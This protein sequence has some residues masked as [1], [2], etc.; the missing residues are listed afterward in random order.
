MIKPRTAV[1]SNLFAIKTRVPMIDSSDDLL[2]MISRAVDFTAL[3]SK[4]DRVA[5]GS[6]SI[7]GDHSPFLTETM[8][9]IIMLT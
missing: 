3:A 1:K 6:V 9:R 7:I 2:V 8:A 4:V 5:L